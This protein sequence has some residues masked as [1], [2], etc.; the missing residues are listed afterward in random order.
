MKKLLHNSLFTFI[1][2]ALIFGIGGVLAEYVIFSDNVIYT[3]E[4]DTWEVN[5]VESAL[6]DL[7]D[8]YNDCDNFDYVT[9]R[10]F[11]TKTIS[12]AL[13]TTPYTFTD[14]VGYGIVVISSSNNTNDPSYF[15]AEITSLSAGTYTSLD[16]S[17]TFNNQYGFGHRS[18]IYEIRD[19]PK[20]AIIK[21]Y[22]RY[23]TTVQILK[24]Y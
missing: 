21:F 18:R 22:S 16:N 6:N 13:L 7:Y 15:V 11:M 23:N 14:D 20:N 24:Y 19:V 9:P 2:G 10:V 3:P 12:G 4:N 17:Y 5:N 1:L 8:K